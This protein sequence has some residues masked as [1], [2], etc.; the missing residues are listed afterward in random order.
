LWDAH[1]HEGRLYVTSLRSLYTLDGPGLR[2]VDLGAIVATSFQHL[3][4]AG[5]FLCSVGAFAVCLFDGNTW[6]AV[7]LP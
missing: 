6:T 7:D 1:W 4:S 3:S 5:R 2:R